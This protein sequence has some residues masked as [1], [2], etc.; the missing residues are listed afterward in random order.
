MEYIFKNN[1]DDLKVFLS[2]VQI[3]EKKNIIKKGPIRIQFYDALKLLYDETKDEK[4][5]EFT[6]KYF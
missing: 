2:D 6:M 3:E 4:Y 1:M 5:K